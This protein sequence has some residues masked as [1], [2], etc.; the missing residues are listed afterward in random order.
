MRKGSSR[1]EF[2][3][4]EQKKWVK[5]ED[6][7]EF[8]K[9]EKWY[10][11][12]ITALKLYGPICRCCGIAGRVNVDHIKPFK[13]YPWLRSRIDNLQILCA[14]C[15]K[16]KLNKTQDYR[17]QEDKNTLSEYFKAKANTESIKR[18]R[19]HRKAKSK[20]VQNKKSKVILIKNKNQECL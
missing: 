4:Q 19:R 15:N 12:R 18:K 14:G 7:D 10:R 2:V 13:Y 3:D 17:T 16:A 6:R 11:L 5:K 9:T 8:Y 1:K 20:L